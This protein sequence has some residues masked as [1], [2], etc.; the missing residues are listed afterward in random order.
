MPADISTNFGA[1]IYGPRTNTLY[2]IA[3]QRQLCAVFEPGVELPSD[4]RG[5]VRIEYV[6]GVP[7]STTS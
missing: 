5:I 6:K 3:G 2:R 7:G 4:L 1:E